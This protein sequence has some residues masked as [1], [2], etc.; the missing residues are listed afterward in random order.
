MAQTIAPA[1][2]PTLTRTRLVEIAQEYGIRV[3]YKRQSKLYE[4]EE[5]NYTITY[6]FGTHGLNMAGD[7]WLITRWKSEDDLRAQFLDMVDREER[8]TAYLN[9]WN[10]IV[11]QARNGNA[12]A[13]QLLIEDTVTGVQG[14]IQST[15][16]RVIRKIRAAV[17]DRLDEA[18]TSEH[19]F[20]AL[21][22]IGRSKAEEYKTCW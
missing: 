2:I 14:N 7:C 12:D 17:S 4:D 16:E 21:H 13:R 3:Q 19:P 9:Y 20:A 22:T 18:L 10:G 5:Q 8:L 15:N 1:R 6:H 11:E